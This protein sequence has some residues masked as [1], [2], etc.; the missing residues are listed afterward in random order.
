MFDDL[1][2]D[3]CNLLS[4][5]DAEASGRVK[6]RV[7]MGNTNEADAYRKLQELY[8]D[9]SDS[10]IESM[11]ENIDDLTEIAQ[12]VLRAE[13]AKRGLDAQ[14]RDA[15]PV[16]VAR[17]APLNDLSE[18]DANAALH[19]TGKDADQSSESEV[20]QKSLDWMQPGPVVPR[21]DP[22]AYDPIA[23]WNVADP[24]RARQIMEI[25]ASASIKS[26]LGP[27]N[28]ENVDDYKGSYEDGVE[29]KVMKFQARFAVDGLRR[30]LPPEPQDES[31]DE[32][33]YAICCPKCNS[34]DVIFLGVEA[35]PGKD[36]ASGEKYNWTCDACGHQWKDDGIVEKP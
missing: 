28:V 21:P 7:I 13:I 30:V 3:P 35:E 12:Q 17:H 34:Q 14:S 36:E 2:A 6:F 18:Q 15:A 20:S 31:T 16:E 26:F 9:M 5:V 22:H 24:T 27:D 19:V 23:I 10:R 4:V 29:V 32:A 25:L 33:E 8:A 1:P 11:A